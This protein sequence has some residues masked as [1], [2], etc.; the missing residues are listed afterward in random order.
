MSVQISKKQIPPSNVS[1]RLVD[2][3]LREYEFPIEYI[4]RYDMFH[5]RLLT[6]VIELC[7]DPRKIVKQ[8][9]S[10]QQDEAFPSTGIISRRVRNGRVGTLKL[11]RLEPSSSL[12]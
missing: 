2:T 4:G 11:P 5:V 10:L 12:L 6:T 3:S 7:R 1:L 8:G 9:G